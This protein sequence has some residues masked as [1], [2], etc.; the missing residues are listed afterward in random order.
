[1]PVR[2]LECF[3]WQKRLRLLGFPSSAGLVGDL[4]LLEPEEPEAV[5]VCL[6]GKAAQ[7]GAVLCTHGLGM[8]RQW[9]VW[10][11]QWEVMGKR[12]TGEKG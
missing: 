11:E 10:E 2:L 12:V 8:G 3:F 1:M 5:S 4:G 9:V 6:K 7:A